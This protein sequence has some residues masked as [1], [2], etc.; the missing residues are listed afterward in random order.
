M[1]KIS[2]TNKGSTRKGIGI[3][4]SLIAVFLL[5]INLVNIDFEKFFKRLPN[6]PEVIARMMAIDVSILPAVF[7]N[8]GIS[9][10]LAFLAL[11][12]SVM[13]AFIISLFAANNIAPNRYMAWLIK[14]FFAV[15]R[16]VPSLV[17][18]LMVIASLGFGNN[19]GFLAIF[20][21]SVAY[22]VKM[23]VGSLEDVGTDI[24]ETMNATGA[25]WWNLVFHGVLPLAITGIA[26]W[27]ALRFEGNIEE[28][29]SLG[30]IGVGGIGLLLTQSINSYNY[31]QTTTIVIII[32][33]LLI[34]IE[35]FITKFKQTIKHG[36][37]A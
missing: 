21:P 13:A 27:V 34:S 33:I 18:G 3:A 8:I 24:V 14:G 22:L 9:L 35:V 30:I 28:S 2:V 11:V 20:I 19:A 17:W 16:A 5:A 4:I 7:K 12:M 10:A 1:E 25:S 32:C 15:V 6:A 31:A 37:Q 36:K 26:S 29:I 23:F